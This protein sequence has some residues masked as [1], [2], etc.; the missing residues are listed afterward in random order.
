MG[1][2]VPLLARILSDSLSARPWAQGLFPMKTSLPS[3]G[4]KGSQDWSMTRFAVL[5]YGVVALASLAWAGIVEDRWVWLLPGRSTPDTPI[6]GFLPDWAR[7][8]VWLG[9]GV[10]FGGLVAALGRI[11]SGKVA[12]LDAM[13]E[14]FC[15]L[16]GPIGWGQAFAMASAS[17]LG[18]ELLFR[19][20]ALPAIGLCWSSLIFGLV[21]L[22]MD[23]RF[24]VWPLFAGLVG[25]V[26]GWLTLGSGNLGPAILGHFTVNFFNLVTIGR[27][28]AE[29]L[30][31][32]VA[33]VWARDEHGEGDGR[34]WPDGGTEVADEAERPDGGTE[35][36]DEAERPDGGTDSADVAGGQDGSGE[37]SDSEGA[38]R[39]GGRTPR[40]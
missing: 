6:L 36:A 31:A 21:H 8:L 40:E 37:S 9:A 35:P 33:Q 12:W 23:R 3:A 20:V 28:A 38:S 34:A 18:E 25:L 10:S 11:A 17:A 24:A 4:S 30:P 32:G 14:G 13:E 15:D 27:K 29:R 1:V 19:G 5:F 16:V 22:P 26:L 39:E 2:R 7:S